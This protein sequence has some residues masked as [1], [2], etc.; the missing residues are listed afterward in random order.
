[1][2]EEQIVQN[3]IRRLGQSQAERPA[4]ELDEHFVDID[5]RD[6]KRL[7]EF[8]ARLAPNIR[9]QAANS[10]TTASWEPF[11]RR[12][13]INRVLGATDAAVTPHLALFAAFLGLYNQ[14][15]LVANRLTAAHLA[16]FYER[17]LG[18]KP[19]PA[20][21]DRAHV[22]V[23]LKNNAPPTRIGTD[24]RLTAGKGSQGERLFAPTTD[25]II[26]S[27]KVV[28]LRSVFVDSNGT[29][30][31]APIANSADGLGGE[32]QT[33]DRHWSPFG[34]ATQP[35]ATIGF[36]LAS[37]VLRMAEGRRGVTCAIGVDHIDAGALPAAGVAFDAFVTGAKGWLGPYAASASGS[38]A[39]LTLAFSIGAKEAPV[40]DYDAALHG[41]SYSAAAPV[42]Q[43]VVRTTGGGQGLAVLRAA[44]VRTA[45]ID[46]SVAGI[47]TLGLENDLGA[48]DPKRAFLPFGPQPTVGSRFLVSHPEA[49][50]KK[51]STFSLRFKW[52]GRSASFDDLYK[53][54]DE[55]TYGPTDFYAMVSFEDGGSWIE[56]GVNVGLFPT[57]GLDGFS[58]FTFTAG[59]R[60]TSAAPTRGRKMRALRVEPSSWARQAERDVFHIGV[61]SVAI[62]RIAQRFDRVHLNRFLDA[63]DPPRQGAITFSLGHD[64]MHALYRRRVV[65]NAYATT[66]VTLLEPYTPTAQGIEFS[67]TASTGDLDIGSASLDAFSNPDLQFFQ[68]D[69]FGQR[70]DHGYRRSRVPFVLN[71]AV[72]LI[73][74]HPYEGELLIGLDNVAARDSVSLLA[75]VAE[76]T[77]DPDLPAAIVQWSALCDNDWKPLRPEELVSDGS[78]HLRRSGIVSLIVPREATTEHTLMPS[79]LMWLRATVD[80]HSRASCRLVT[81]AANAIE[82]GLVEPL[83]D[84]GHLTTALPPGSIAKLKTP[85][86]GV[87]AVSQPFASFGGRPLESAAALATR[88]SE[89]LRHKARCI[90]PWDYERMVLESFPRV[91]RVKCVPHAREGAW[92][93]PGHVLLVVVPDLRDRVVAAAAATTDPTEPVAADLLQPRVDIDTLTNIQAFVQNHCGPQ[94]SVHVKNPAYRKI[95]LSFGVKFHRGRDFHYHRGLLTN[96]L[97]RFLSPWAFDSARQLTFGGR[98]YRSV[99]IDFVEELDYV[100]YL[101]SFRMVVQSGAGI[102]EAFEAVPDQPDAILVSDAAHDIT[103]VV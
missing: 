12:E 86:A 75:Q 85:L 74:E 70:R 34:S 69:A 48:L 64:F 37:P 22:V 84:V 21:P 77:A 63:A 66:K 20:L 19:R 71:P 56:H 53:N 8:A 6:P 81:I 94:I 10:T 14:T 90:S 89:R 11:F 83:A 28:S 100:D 80:R 91:H 47:T 17:V 92:L 62:G 43:F 25:T 41:L 7:L 44:T 68:V 72:P 73:A 49:L 51:L 24:H 102:S 58:T 18:F 5:E 96:A 39:T 13:D 32:W 3:L 59:S 15:R 88:A 76:D 2:A 99:L 60:S 50:G 42:V 95:R 33:A 4:A 103:E 82:T 38:G 98:V 87:K 46:V 67:Y 101:T 31:A 55:H 61:P 57:V 36:A 93:S 78:H 29:V 40:V 54:Y 79:G 23:E 35:T 45:R 16:F 1:M 26:R 52:L 27:A 9:Y 65:E 97:I 30:H